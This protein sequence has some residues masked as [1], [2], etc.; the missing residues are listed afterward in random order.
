MNS[1]REPGPA[2]V[3]GAYPYALRIDHEGLLSLRLERPGPWVRFDPRDPPTD[4][5]VVVLSWTWPEHLRATAAALASGVRVHVVAPAPVRDWLLAQ[6]APAELLHDS[7]FQIEGM[8]IQQAPYQ[9]IPWATPIEAARKLRSALLRPDRALRRLASH[10]GL[11]DS[12]PQ[13]TAITFPDG[14][15][16]LNLSL[17][18]HGGT[19]ADWL[20]RVVA[21]HRGCDWLLCG[22]DFEE[23][24]ALQQHLG[25]FEARTILVVDL[26]GEV[27]RSIGMPSALLTPLVD[28]LQAQGLDA[29]VF[30]S[31][32]SFRFE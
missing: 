23:E 32:V 9:P 29:Y 26:L 25:R 5:Q 2:A 3:P 4:G 1:P 27:R 16:L 11:P 24:A 21:E 8:H 28:Q 7:P 12:Q 6:G 10:R 22:C 14:R 18:L 17:A 20:D 31:K 13:I 30:A 19:P 15:R